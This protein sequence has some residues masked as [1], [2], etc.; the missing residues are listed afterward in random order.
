MV[1]DILDLGRHYFIVQHDDRPP[2]AINKVGLPHVVLPILLSFLRFHAFQDGDPKMIW[3]SNS[4]R[5][6][7][8]N[9]DEQE[10]AM[11]FHIGTTTVQ[12]FFKGTHRR[13]LRQV[14]DL[15]CLTWIFVLCWV[16]QVQF[17]QSFLPTHLSFTLL[18]LHLGQLCWCKG[19][20]IFGIYGIKDLWV[21]GK[22]FLMWRP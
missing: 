9:V 18:H 1:D 6:E 7:E 15:I 2:L 12:R 4:S 13:I 3:D 8:P 10:Q 20:V 17:T 11:G 19:E 5:V 22:R 21:M 14:M 16:E